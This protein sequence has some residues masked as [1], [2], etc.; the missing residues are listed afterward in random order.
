MTNGDDDSDGGLRDSLNSLNARLDEIFRVDPTNTDDQRSQM[1]LLLKAVHDFL[2]PHRPALDPVAL[3]LFELAAALDDLNDGVAAPLMQ[4]ASR[5]NRRGSAKGKPRDPNTL[6]L[7]RAAVCVAFRALRSA[8]KTRDE[9]AR[10]I[11]KNHKWTRTIVGK[12]AMGDPTQAIKNWDHQLSSGLA[13]VAAA[14]AAYQRG[15]E[16]LK[17]AQ[18]AGMSPPAMEQWAENMLKVRSRTRTGN[19]LEPRS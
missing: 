9:A 11:A 4:A 6:W 12:R 1:M 8:G 16:L 5:K 10:L 17:A 13:P 2:R 14:S 19:F 7:D 18:E 15:V 3:S